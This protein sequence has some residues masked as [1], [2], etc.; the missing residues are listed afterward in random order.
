MQLAFPWKE[1]LKTLYISITLCVVTKF[2]ELSYSL[3]KTPEQL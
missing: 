2:Y 1:K 3:N